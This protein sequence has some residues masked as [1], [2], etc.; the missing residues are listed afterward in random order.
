MLLTNYKVG[1]IKVFGPVVELNLLPRSKNVQ[2]LSNNVA[3]KRKARALKSAI[4]YG[5]NNTGKSSLFESLRMMKKIFKDGHI[6][7]FPFDVYKNFCYSFDG[8]I[9]FELTCKDEEMT[10]TYGIEFKDHTHLGEYL[11]RDGTLLFSR[12][13][14]GESEGI[15][16]KQREFISRVKDLP[17]HKLVI[18]YIVEYSKAANQYREFGRIHELFSRMHFLNNSENGVPV[19]LVTKFMDDPKRMTLLNRV[20]QSA[21]L[22]MEKRAILSEKE[23]MQSKIFQDIIHNNFADIDHEEDQEKRQSYKHLSDV[24][25]ITSIYKDKDGNDLFLPSAIYDSIGT[26]K[27]IRLAIVILMALLENHILFI[28]ELD[29]SLHHKLTRVLI[30]LMNSKS[31]QG[32][33]FIMSTH[34]VTLLSSQLFRKDQI[35]FLSRNQ[36][37]V[38]LIS[39]ADFKANSDRDIRSNSNFEKMYTEEKIVPLPNTDIYEVIQAFQEYVSKATSVANQ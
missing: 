4:L 28:D 18:P 17:Y 9:R 15:F 31:N 12:G 36:C 6:D 37:N 16:M 13:L 23:L 26:N 32:A 24:L 21:D 3:G 10:L 27:F 34:D 14:D 39:L 1:G 5:A 19:A 35:N 33:Q 2:H 30:I 22:F 29:S 7:N 25:K 8:V 11:Y 38:E 20:I